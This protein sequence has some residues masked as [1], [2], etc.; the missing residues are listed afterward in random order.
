[1]RSH[2][3]NIHL[4]IKKAAILVFKSLAFS[5]L[6]IQ[7]KGHMQQYKKW[8]KIEFLKLQDLFFSHRS[9]MLSFPFLASLSL[10]MRSSPSSLLPFP[11][12]PRNWMFFWSVFASFWLHLFSQYLC[13]YHFCWLRIL[14]SLF[15]IYFGIYLALCLV[16]K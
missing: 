9:W 16:W 5:L 13:R 1:M 4:N 3:I 2:L 15:P 14:I 10:T 12:C 11:T 7:W 6:P 8:V